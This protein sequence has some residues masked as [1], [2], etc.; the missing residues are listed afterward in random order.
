MCWI[1][2]P[3]R[4]NR[5]VTVLTCSLRFSLVIYA[6]I[7]WQFT[8]STRRL[9]FA[10]ISS[11]HLWPV[12]SLPFHKNHSLS[13]NPPW[14]AFSFHSLMQAFMGKT[15]PQ[16]DGVEFILDSDCTCDECSLSLTHSL[17][18]LFM[19]GLWAWGWV[20]LI[21]SFEQMIESLIWYWFGVYYKSLKI[22]HL[23]TRLK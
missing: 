8:C 15:H 12:W 23:K 20:T 7:F 13:A 11:S 14:Y 9:L 16:E 6:F 1:S 19:A 4:M 22:N 2:G 18:G 10:R 5:M 17:F 3:A 21:Y